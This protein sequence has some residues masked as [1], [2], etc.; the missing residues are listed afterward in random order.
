VPP[1]EG[2]GAT[3]VQLQDVGDERGASGPDGVVDTFVAGTLR[4]LSANAPQGAG[5]IATEVGDG[6]GEC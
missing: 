2:R 4:R 6:Y 3:V 1:A 5:A